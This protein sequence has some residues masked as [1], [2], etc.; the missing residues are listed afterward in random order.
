[1]KKLFTLSIAC[2]AIA[3]SSSQ[4]RAEGGVAIVDLDAVAKELNVIEFIEVTLAN[5]GT[6]LDGDLKSM[7]QN[8]QSEFDSEKGKVEQKHGG[9]IEKASNE[10]KQALLVKNRDLQIQFNQARNQAAQTMNVRKLE[11]ISK[12]RNELKPVALEVAKKK[13]MDVVLNKVM[14]PV[15]VYS[16]SVDITKDVAAAAKAAGMTKT[17][18][19]RKT[20]Q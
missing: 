1:M 8:L 12:F 13:G 17:V 18:P 19:E 9:D 16:D 5:L 4:A 11:M 14:P 2:L 7:Q 15:Y 10:E 20:A 3:F 6:G